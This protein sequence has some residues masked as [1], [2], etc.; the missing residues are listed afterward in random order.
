MNG[1]LLL[2]EVCERFRVEVIEAARES[3]AAL[4]G[5]LHGM[6]QQMAEEANQVERDRE[7]I[8]VLVVDLLSEIADTGPPPDLH[9]RLEALHSAL[10]N[11]TVPSYDGSLIDQ[12]HLLCLAALAE[13]P[14]PEC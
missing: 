3:F 10:G 12:Q 8:D 6:V 2:T 11:L 5:R 4:A 7:A 13:L 1:L 14:E 9:A